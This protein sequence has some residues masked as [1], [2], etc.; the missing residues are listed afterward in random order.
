MIEGKKLSTVALFV[1]LIENKQYQDVF[2]ELTSSG[3]FQESLTM[4]M[5]LYPSI[6]K[7][8]HTKTLVRK[9]QS[10]RNVK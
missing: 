10:T 9:L 1:A 2:V 8:K 5:F 7:S 6:A 4:M 3:S